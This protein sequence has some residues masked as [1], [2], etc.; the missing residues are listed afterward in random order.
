MDFFEE[1]VIKNP[2]EQRRAADTKRERR[3]ADRDRP[4]TH[5]LFFGIG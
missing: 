1:L 5:K 3:E 2:A 4:V